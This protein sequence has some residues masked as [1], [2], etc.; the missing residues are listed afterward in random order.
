M[1]EGGRLRTFTEYNV[2]FAHGGNI[3]VPLDRLRRPTADDEA[4]A[5]LVLER[6]GPKGKH[7]SP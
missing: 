5:R 7:D 2:V 6:L 1:G 4:S 3:R